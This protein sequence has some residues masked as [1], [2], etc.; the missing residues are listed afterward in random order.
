MPYPIAN[1]AYGLRCRLSE[2][3]THNERCH[4]QVAAGDV[5]NCP[6]KLQLHRHLN[7]NFT[8]VARSLGENPDPHQVDY[9]SNFF[10]SKIDRGPLVDLGTEILRPGVAFW[11]RYGRLKIGF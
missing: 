7:A 8:I 5:S 4:I 9:P 6:P 3:A 2:L 11:L 10:I 1:L